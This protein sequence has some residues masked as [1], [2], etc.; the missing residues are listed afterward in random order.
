MAY[1]QKA[2]KLNSIYIKNKQVNKVK[3]LFRLV[4]ALERK[5]KED[6]HDTISTT[7]R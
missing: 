4:V 3:H 2:L 7:N 5:N 6:H 1:K